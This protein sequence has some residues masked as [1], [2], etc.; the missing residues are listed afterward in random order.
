MIKTYMSIIDIYRAGQNTTLTENSLEKAGKIILSISMLGMWLEANNTKLNGGY[1]RLDW[2]VFLFVTS[3]TYTC[4]S[5]N[6][7]VVK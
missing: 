3:D 1:K 5:K 4:P 2:L 7:R 6:F